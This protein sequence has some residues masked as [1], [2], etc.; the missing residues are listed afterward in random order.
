MKRIIAFVVSIA[1]MSNTISLNAQSANR[2]H[3]EDPFRELKKEWA[4]PNIFRTASG[5][6]GP[7]YYQQKADYDIKVK[8]DDEKTKVFGEATI[9]Y[10]NNSPDKLEY[11]WVQ[12][13]Q[14]TRRKD[15]QNKLTKEQKLR[16]M[17]FEDFDKLTNPFDGGYDFEYVRN[18]NG[19]PLSHTINWTMMRINLT[20]PLEPGDKFTFKV[21]WSFNINN[22]LKDGG[23]SGYEPFE[24]GNRIYVM[25][26]WFPRMAVYNDVY[27]W[28]NHQFWGRSEFALVFGDYDVKIQV[29]DDFVVAST[30]TLENESSVLNSTQRAR[31][32]KARKSY[33]EPVVII[34]QEEAVKN[35]DSRSK[36]YKTWEFEA[37]NVRDFAFS[38]SRK[39][40]WDAM[41]VKVGK[42]TVLAYS[43]YP[44]EGNPLWGQYSTRAVAHT[45]KTY[46][47]Y[48]FDYPYP[49]AISIHAKWQGM[50][51][52]MICWNYG[53][54]ESDGTYSDRVKY[55]MLGVIIH[56]VGHNFFP[57]IVNSDERQWTWMDEGLN[58]FLEFL[59][60]QEFQKDYPSRRGFPD[61]IVDYMLTDPD[62]IMPIMTKGD[63]VFQFG[64]NAYAK[65]ATALNILRETIL[66]RELFDYAF[67]MYSKRW[68]FKH[69]TPED[70]FRTMEDAS[71][72]ELDWFWRGW[73]Y[74]I[75]YNDIGI[76]EVELYTVVKDP[77]DL[78]DFLK[79]KDQYKIS[80][81][82]T[83]IA[84]RENKVTRY[85]PQHPEA[86]DFYDKNSPFD[87]DKIDEQGF[88]KYKESLSEEQLSMTQTSKLF[89]QITFEKL[90]GLVMPII[91][92]FTYKDNT[93]EKI[94]I[95]AQ[96]W[97]RHDEEVTK[98]FAVD[99]EITKIEID[100]NLETAD[101]NLSNNQW[102]AKVKTSKFRL[103]KKQK[104]TSRG[105]S[106]EENRI[107]RAQRASKL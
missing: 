84:N 50:E 23:R 95:P 43:Y 37:E 66:G 60:E 70:F 77:K 40:I 5:A 36:K 67:K 52:P 30:G 31:L 13:D 76:K 26:Q 81:R 69:P 9:T 100:P 61:Q 55:G 7:R 16:N 75:D 62:K 65:P 73:F 12:L 47:K 51:Y 96:I 49:K 93:K 103:Y 19:S 57:M 78:K 63:E 83:N 102:P 64:N 14:N 8:L 6:P 20:E 11:L 53:R 18:K 107:Q 90:G 92:E 33:N 86:E 80:H 72:T 17:S 79:E 2:K 1:L 94:K 15:A 22:Y 29:P 74:T 99:K 58:T 32:K 24:D 98:V 71:G 89:Y 59:T 28:Q 88:A 35:K 10:Y 106:L 56:E 85:V 38:A 4:T 42:K 104:P 46:S 3:R 41:A 97:R 54:P 101:V 25:A 21:K 68:M 48:T 82:Q 34:N 91:V 44:P 105:G 39:F 27:G 45:L 87:I